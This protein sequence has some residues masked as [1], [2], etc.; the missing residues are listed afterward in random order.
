VPWHGIPRRALGYLAAGVALFTLQSLVLIRAI[1][2]FGDA[3]GA[4]VVYSSRGLWGIVF[5]WLIGSWFGNRELHACPPR[6]I[7]ARVAGAVLVSIA[8]VLVFL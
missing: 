7:W 1:G 4:N 8:T 2:A 3:A 5:V 6:V